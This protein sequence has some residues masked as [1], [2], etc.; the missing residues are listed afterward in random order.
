MNKASSTCTLIQYQ[1]KYS[2]ILRYGDAMVFKQGSSDVT[3]AAIGN[4]LNGNCGKHELESE[5]R[6]GTNWPLVEQMQH[7]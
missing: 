6:T 3:T 2:F 4:L 7:L 5:K 1:K